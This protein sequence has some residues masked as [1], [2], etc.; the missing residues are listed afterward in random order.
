MT[1]RT[2][3]ALSCPD[4]FE[5]REALDELDLITPRVDALRAELAELAESTDRCFSL[6]TW[7]ERL[8]REP[9]SIGRAR[10]AWLGIGRNARDLVGGL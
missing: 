6:V 5:R 9:E 3:P 8:E 10:A 4:R 1:H 2:T 7:D